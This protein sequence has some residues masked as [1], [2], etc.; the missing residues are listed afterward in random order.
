[1]L[2]EENHIDYINEISTN[3]VIIT[4]IIRNSN[5]QNVLNNH[6]DSV[7]KYNYCVRNIN[8]LRLVG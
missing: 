3:H 7:Y 5:F 2:T 4:N 1:V 6:G 8:V